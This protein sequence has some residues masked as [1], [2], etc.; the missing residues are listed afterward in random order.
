MVKSSWVWSMFDNIMSPYSLTVHRAGHPWDVV[1]NNQAIFKFLND[2]TADIFVK[3][4]VDQTYPLNYFTDMVPLARIY[5]MI[6]PVIYDRHKQNDFKTLAFE[7]K[8]DLLGSWLDVS[9]RLGIE[10]YP[11]THTNNFYRRDVLEGIQPPWYEAHL[12]EDGLSRA[13]HVDF[14]FLDKI[15]A[16]GQECW[17]NH[18]VVVKHIAD[19]E[20]DR[21]FYERNKGR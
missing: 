18:D 19:C 13:N 4:D 21:E 1:R 17:L 5:G 9:D 12:S 11:Y 7:G 6:G 3:M 2:P 15:K 20:V 8:E 16:S 10:S 14:D